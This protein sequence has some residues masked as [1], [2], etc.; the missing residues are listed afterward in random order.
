MV[1]ARKIFRHM[2]TSHMLIAHL[3]VGL[4]NMLSFA[5]KKTRQMEVANSKNRNRVS[6]RWSLRDFYVSIKMR[7]FMLSRGGLAFPHNTSVA[8]KLY[9]G[10]DIDC[11][12]V[13]CALPCSTSRCG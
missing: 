11:V 13:I 5:G 10:K 7:L 2:Q 6:R 1:A 12:R 4:I 9:G 3:L 8:L